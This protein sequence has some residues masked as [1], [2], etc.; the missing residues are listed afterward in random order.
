[1]LEPL[2]LTPITRAPKFREIFVFAKILTFM[3]RCEMETRINFVP[4]IF[5]K[6]RR[7]QIE[8]FARNLGGPGAKLWSRASLGVIFRIFLSHL[9]HPVP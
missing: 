8:S 9:L 6:F 3:S 5:A 4:E 7:L 1:M 2:T